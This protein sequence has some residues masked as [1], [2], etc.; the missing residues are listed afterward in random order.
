MNL[1]ERVMRAMAHGV[2]G[3]AMGMVIWI[4]WEGLQV[5]SGER[6]IAAPPR[7]STASVPTGPL[8]HRLGLLDKS[9]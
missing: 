5:I 8:V 9:A 1:N 4:A 3:C 6:K 2:M 7:S